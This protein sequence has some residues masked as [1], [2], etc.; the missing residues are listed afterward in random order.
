MEQISF[1][2]QILNLMIGL[3]KDHPFYRPTSSNIKTLGYYL[4]GVERGFYVGRRETTPE[5]MASSSI[6]GHT[7]MIESTFQ[8]S[9]NNSKQNQIENYLKVSQKEL[10]GSAGLPSADCLI[11]TTWVIVRQSGISNYQ[12]IDSW[13]KT[14][15]FIL[16]SF[17]PNA[18][19]GF[20]LKQLHGAFLDTDLDRLLKPEINFARIYQGY[21]TI[22]TDNLNLEYLAQ[23]TMQLFASFIVKNRFEFN[24]ED[25]AKG[26]IPVWS[27]FN[28]E[29]RKSVITGIDKL[30]STLKKKSYSENLIQRV[31]GIEKQWEIIT[32]DDKPLQF[33]QNKLLKIIAKFQTEY[34]GGQL[35]LEMEDT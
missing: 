5:I 27:E 24:I 21:V 23:P 32:E 34:I 35:S 17:N 25:I 3:F 7:L 9:L 22:P 13:P 11:N 8:N 33:Y 15:G 6:S 31:V 19:T 2:L 29:K 28:Y 10:S 16:S 4:S 20:Q 14:N 1:N 30:F 26:L 12:V 18:S